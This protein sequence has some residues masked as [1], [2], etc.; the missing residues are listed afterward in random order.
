MPKSKRNKVVPLTKVKKKTKEWKEGVITQVRNS[1][2][3]YPSI[4]LFKYANFRNDKFKEL[5]D[6]HRAT[7]RR[8][9]VCLMSGQDGRVWTRG[10]R[11]GFCLGSNKMLRVALGHDAADEYRAG[12]AGLSERIRGSMGLFFTKLPREEVQR[13]F[14]GFE[15]QD[16]ARAGARATEDF[17]L[18]E[19]P[20]T[21]YGEPLPHTLEPQ[22]RQHG[23]PTKLV[24]GVVTLVADYQVCK[25]GQKLQPAQAALLRI[26]DQKQATFRMQLLAVWENDAVEELAE[27]GSEEEEEGGGSG[28]FPDVPF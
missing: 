28:D 7:S 19:G 5:R 6:E 2:D 23:M 16:Y 14:D 13:I 20:L 12:L 18:E 10:G 11:G 22:L 3:E 25:A 8:A 27:D 24:K 1:A 9:P 4:Y 26:F 17:A 15:V 21:L